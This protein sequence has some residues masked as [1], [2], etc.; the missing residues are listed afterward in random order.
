M[1]QR[2]EDEGWIWQILPSP[3]KRKAEHEAYIIG[4]EK[5]WRTSPLTVHTAYLQCLLEAENLRSKFGIHAIPHGS[6][7]VV[8]SALLKG[9]LPSPVTKVA[10]FTLEDDLPQAPLQNSDPQ[11]EDYHLAN[12]PIDDDYHSQHEN[13]EE[14][15]NRIMELIQQDTLQEDSKFVAD[16]VEPAALEVL[17]VAPD[18]S[19]ETANNIARL[20][21]H[22]E[23]GPC[24]S[25]PAHTGSRKI[26]S[27]G[28]QE[29]S[30]SGFDWRTFKWAAFT[31]TS[32]RPPKLGGQGAY[33]WQAS[34]PFHAKNDKTGCRKFCNVSPLTPENFKNVINCLKAWCNNARNC[35]TQ[36]E[37]MAL[38]VSPTSFPP[39]AVI[40]AA[41]IPASDK[42]AS[43]VKIDVKILQEEA[44]NSSGAVVAPKRAAK[45]VPKRKAKPKPKARMDDKH[46]SKNS[47]SNSSQKRGSDSNS[48]SDSSSS[49]SGKNSSSSSSSSS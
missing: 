24:P 19:S 21:D 29:A 32:K 48:D 22:G 46:S 45:T 25:E 49:S 9:V 26:V 47:S 23:S 13:G 35:R 31:F 12:V 42:P 10:R 41:C 20:E 15:I 7:Q 18:D 2:L 36:A 44:G 16:A 14:S 39:P 34:C 4:D 5:I 11:E 38:S 3:K 17:G 37:H 30:N 43:K 40:E 33:V 6:T 8:Y 28:V 27:I 1:I